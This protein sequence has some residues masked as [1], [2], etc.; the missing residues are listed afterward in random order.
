[1]YR[2]IK[3]IVGTMFK[4]IVRH[5]MVQTKTQIKLYHKYFV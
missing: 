4:I 5:P 1:M 2:Y 3:K